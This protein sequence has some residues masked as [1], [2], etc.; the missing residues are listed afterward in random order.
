MYLSLFTFMITKHNKILFLFLFS[1]SLS[2]EVKMKLL[3]FKY[4]SIQLIFAIGTYYVQ[5]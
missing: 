5:N 2:K 1:L 4:T 3:S